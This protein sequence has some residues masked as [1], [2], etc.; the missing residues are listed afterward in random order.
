MTT[1]LYGLTKFARELGI[2]VDRRKLSV[3]YH[4]GKLPK[5]VAFAGVN[6]RRPLWSKDQIKQYKKIWVKNYQFL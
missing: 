4:R 5:P 2:N 6:G 1:E 3:Y